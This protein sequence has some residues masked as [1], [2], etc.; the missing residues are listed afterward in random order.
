MKDEGD[1]CKL[2]LKAAEE[3]TEEEATAS[4]KTMAA[5][6]VISQDA[7]VEAFFLELDGLIELNTLE[8]ISLVLTDLSMS[9]AKHSGASRLTTGWRYTCSV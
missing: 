7:A 6:K 3:D 8:A 5:A 2:P 9:L 4:C 1:C